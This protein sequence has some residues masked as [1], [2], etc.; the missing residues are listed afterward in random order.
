MQRVRLRAAPLLVLGL[1][2]LFAGPAVAADAPAGHDDHNGGVFGWALDL[3][4][5]T[6]VVFLLLLFILTKYA[7]G[8]MLEALRQREETIR[9]A[10]EEAK[11]ARAETD[12]VRAEF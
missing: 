2:L 8:P 4:I 5:W 11:L 10:V 1:V 9:G 12:R 7:W 6:L 3:G